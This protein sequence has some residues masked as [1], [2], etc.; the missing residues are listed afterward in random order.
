VIF[1]SPSPNRVRKNGDI[2]YTHRNTSHEIPQKTQTQ[3]A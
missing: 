1:D 2:K 3:N